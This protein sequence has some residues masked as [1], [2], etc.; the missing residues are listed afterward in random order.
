[1]PG[2]SSPFFRLG[3]GSFE[4]VWVDVVVEFEDEVDVEVSGEPIDV[5][6]VFVS[7]ALGEVDEV[8]DKEGSGFT[9]V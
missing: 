6:A 7:E 8:G 1:M 5:V 4:F 9:N 3:N 2:I